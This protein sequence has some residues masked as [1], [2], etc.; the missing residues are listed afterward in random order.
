MRNSRGKTQYKDSKLKEKTQDS[1]KK[2][3]TQGKNSKLKKKLN[4]SAYSYVGHEEN[5]ANLQAC[6]NGTKIL[7]KSPKC[8]LRKCHDIFCQADEQT[9]CVMLILFLWLFHETMG[10]GAFPK[11]G[12]RDSN[13]TLVLCEKAKR[14]LLP[15]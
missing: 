15:G 8:H 10:H 14:S 1:M 5:V 13:H 7:A 3:K 12:N 9:Q 4:F 2:L 6:N 11:Q